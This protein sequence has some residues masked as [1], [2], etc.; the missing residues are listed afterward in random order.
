MKAS[1]ANDEF[2]RTPP[3]ADVSGAS[4]AWRQLLDLCDRMRF[5]PNEITAQ[6]D[7]CGHYRVPLD[8]EFLLLS[9]G[10]VDR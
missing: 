2:T 8:G 6:L 1:Q 9:N 7:A 3:R 10:N 4:D 5:E